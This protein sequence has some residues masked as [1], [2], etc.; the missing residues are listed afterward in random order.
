M[1]NCGVSLGAA[2][3]GI[4]PTH[5]RDDSP[6]R[7][8]PVLKSVF[9]WLLR[10]VLGLLLLSVVL[11]FSL[12]FVDPPVWSWKL[13]RSLFN[14]PGY[15][16][17]VRQQWAPL[18]QI[19]RPMQLAVIAAEDQR[20]VQHGGFDLEAIKAALDHNENHGRVRG[21][22]TISQQTAKNLFL[23]PSRS[24]LRKGME[25]W[26]TLLMELL[27]D[28]ARILELYLNVAEFGPGIYGVDAASRYYFGKPARQ[29][30]WSESARMAAVLPN[31]YRY[32][33][34]PPTPYVVERS[35]W[36]S[37]QMGQLGFITLSRL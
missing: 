8:P 16:A 2:I 21:A 10:I 14:P 36:I 35:Q 33:V 5:S 37:Q 6:V 34:N 30:S 1:V 3:M 13:H 18:T 4:F 22:S 7:S 9:R 19:A 26:L 25:A 24:Y 11:V 23:W 31:P 32:R 17:Q 12:R 15:P 29:L 20:F 27:L 28:K